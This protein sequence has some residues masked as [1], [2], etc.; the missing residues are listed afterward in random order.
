MWPGV[1]KFLERLGSK[2]SSS[3]AVVNLVKTETLG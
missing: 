1:D 2:Y 3:A